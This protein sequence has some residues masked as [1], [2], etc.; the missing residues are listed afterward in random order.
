[1]NERNTITNNLLFTLLFYAEKLIDFYVK[2]RRFFHEFFHLN[3]ILFS[4]C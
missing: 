3:K 2:H 1:M 4:Y